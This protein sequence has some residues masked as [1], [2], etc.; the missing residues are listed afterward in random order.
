M[1]YCGT[2]TSAGAGLSMGNVPFY[3]E[4]VDFVM[5]LEKALE[6]R[7][8]GY[9]VGAE[10]KHSCCVLLADRGRYFKGGEADVAGAVGEGRWHTLI[11]YSKFFDC[12]ESGKPFGP[13]HYIGGPTPEWANW[14]R[15]GFDPRDER[16]DRKGRKIENA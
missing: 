16:V 6:R 7:G 14:G 11:D 10:H 15:G 13:E 12:L 3:E 2:S 9:G 5:A 1:T 8:L 4:V